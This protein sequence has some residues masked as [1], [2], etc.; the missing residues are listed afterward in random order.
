MLRFHQALVMVFALSKTVARMMLFHVEI[1][2]GQ[3]LLEFHSKVRIGVV[4]SRDLYEGLI[5]P[6]TRF[7]LAFTGRFGSINQMQ[8][9]DVLT[10]CCWIET[11][12][13]PVQ[14]PR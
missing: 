14:W 1:H 7:G 12:L 4:S 8:F 2:L 3:G 13:N 9:S 5:S 10:N 11:R 6:G